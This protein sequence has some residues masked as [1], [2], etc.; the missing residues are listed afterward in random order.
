M[1]RR[2]MISNEITGSYNFQSMEPKHSCS[3]FIV[4]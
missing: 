3:I 1:A 4:V 2:R